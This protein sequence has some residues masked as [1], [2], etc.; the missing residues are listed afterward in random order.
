MQE[1]GT[2]PELDL[3]SQISF[4]VLLTVPIP[5]HQTLAHYF[6]AIRKSEI[7]FSMKLWKQ[8][9]V[10]GK[11]ILFFFFFLAQQRIMFMTSESLARKKCFNR[12]KNWCKKAL[13]AWNWITTIVEKIHL[14]FWETKG[15]KNWW[16]QDKIYYAQRNKDHLNRKMVSIL[17]MCK[18]FFF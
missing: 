1:N 15:C 11:I 7:C 13:Y 3:S 5:A 12:K 4:S 14:T 17:S 9:S 10:N 18:F 6:I 2:R 16:D 8:I